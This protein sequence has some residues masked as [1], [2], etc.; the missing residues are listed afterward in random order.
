LKKGTGTSR[1]PFF[2]GK[3]ACPFGA[4]PL[5]Q[6]AARRLDHDKAIIANLWLVGQQKFCGGGTKVAARWALCWMVG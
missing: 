3:F 5:F 4:S 2:A 6:R 1:L